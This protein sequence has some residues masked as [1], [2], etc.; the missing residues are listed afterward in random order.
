M[1]PCPKHHAQLYLGL[2][3]GEG[4]PTTLSVGLPITSCLGR[5]LVSMALPNSGAGSPYQQC[6]PPSPTSHTEGFHSWG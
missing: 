5:D 6:R 4:H 1:G 3:H 2:Q